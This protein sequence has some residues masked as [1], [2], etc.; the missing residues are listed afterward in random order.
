LIIPIYKGNSKPKT[1][2]NSY[3]PISLIPCLSK[4]LDR[5][6]VERMR[7]ILILNNVTFPNPQQQGFQEN[8]S[9]IT[10]AFN[11]QETILHNIEQ[12]SNVYVAQLDIKGAFDSVWHDALFYKLGMMGI[13]GKLL[14]ILKSSY[15]DLKCRI[16]INGSTS[17]LID[18]KRGVRQG[19]VTSSFLWLIFINDLLNEL[20]TSKLGA[21]VDDL[22]CSNPTLADDITLVALS[23][24]NLQSMLNIVSRYSSKF[25]LEIST[26]KSCVLAFSSK[27]SNLPLHVTYN[28]HQME[29]VQSTTHLGMSLSTCLKT[30]PKVLERCQ[31]GKNSFH[32]MIGYG[33]HPKG[34]NPLTSASLYKK[35]VIPTI[36]YGSELWNNMT[37]KDLLTLNKTQHYVVKCIQGFQVQTRSDICESMLGLYRLNSEVDKRKLMFLHKILS[38]SHEHITKS[39]FIRR[40]M[41]FLQNPS[42]IT[43]SFISD[44]VKLLSRYHLQYLINNYIAYNTVPSKY[45]WKRIIQTSVQNKEHNEW[46]L[47]LDTDRDFERFKRVHLGIEPAVLWRFPQ[48]RRDLQLAHT[49]SELWVARPDNEMFV[50]AHCEQIVTDR[51]RHIISDCLL[52]LKIKDDFIIDIE[53]YITDNEEISEVPYDSETF[54]VYVLGACV[55]GNSII[56]DIHKHDLTSLSYRFI[57]RCLDIYYSS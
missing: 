22:Q 38:L 13:K 52:T 42:S 44:I 3:R 31:K 37:N 18:V 26:S 35:V 29:Q 1:N 51:F 47:R 55:N 28:G 8:L 54:L 43:K 17:G 5:I 53:R 34:I 4:V 6:L 25:K 19:G 15:K 10:T 46:K 32:A 40:Y 24:A 50:C 11:L 2:P 14:R 7:T 41:K 16:K 57:S 20:T 36:L 23:P 48:H 27:K 21:C 49:I 56:N 9:C 12:N 30:E 33:V 45:E 39:I